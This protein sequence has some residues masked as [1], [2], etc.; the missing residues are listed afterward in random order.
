MPYKPG[1]RQSPTTG[2]KRDKR[3]DRVYDR[4]RPESH[5]L[6]S[7]SRWQKLREYKKHRNPL[8]EECL[9]N[10]VITPATLVDH[11]LPIAEGGAPFDIAN[12][13]SL[14]A[15]CHNKKHAEGRGRKKV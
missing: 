14:C 6:Y 11:I 5:R 15:A 1:T 9:R 7:T 13:Q 4:M 10:H 3:Y 12:L 2:K 8:C